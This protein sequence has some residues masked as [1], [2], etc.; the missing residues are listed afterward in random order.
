MRLLIQVPR[1]PIQVPKVLIQVLR[2]P[3]QAPRVP[4][5]VPVGASSTPNASRGTVYPQLR[6]RRDYIKIATPVELTNSS[7]HGREHGGSGYSEESKG[8]DL[9]EK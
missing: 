1:V 8:H 5:Q 6:D 3:L 9:G 4:I 7:G 2:V